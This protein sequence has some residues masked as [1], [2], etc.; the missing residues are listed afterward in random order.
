[1]KNLAKLVFLWCS[2]CGC[3]LWYYQ[4]LCSA[5]SSTTQRMLDQ[6][7]LS[8]HF[9][10]S[11]LNLW[12]FF[13]DHLAT[14]FP[15]KLYFSLSSLFDW[16]NPTAY[17]LA[18]A[19]EYLCAYLVH[20]FLLWL[21]LLGFGGF[22]GGFILAKQWKIDLKRLKKMAKVK[23][24]EGDLFKQLTEYIRS[25]SRAKELSKLFTTKSITR[26]QLKSYFFSRMIHKFTDVEEMTIFV[27]VMGSVIFLCALMMMIQMELR[28][29]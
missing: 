7:H 18:I 17:I 11:K 3:Q 8:C 12:T 27:G 28:V 10:Y 2:N 26:D 29:E 1:M 16:K 4:K 9:H 14:K 20:Y 21:A 19:W 22:Y 5:I 6:M 24:P 15:N 23:K 13:I 25:H